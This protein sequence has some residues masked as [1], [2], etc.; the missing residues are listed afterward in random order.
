MRKGLSRSLLK[1][2]RNI[3]LKCKEFDSSSSINAIFSSCE[4]SDYLE[5]LRDA[6]SPSERID[7]VISCLLRNP[8]EDKPKFVE[9]LEILLDRYDPIDPFFDELSDCISRVQ[10]E[11]RG[12]KKID[13][14]PFIILAMTNDEAL[15]ML[16]EGASIPEELR[17]LFPSLVSELKK[18]GDEHNIDL[19]NR[20]GKSREDW[21]PYIDSD[22]SIKN[23][24]ESVCSKYNNIKCSE[25][26]KSMICP[27]F[28]SEEFF[29]DIGTRKKLLKSGGIFIIDPFSLFHHKLFRTLSL[30]GV[31][32]ENIP[33]NIAILIQS[34]V[35]SR[36]LNINGLIDNMVMSIANEAYRRYRD[37][38]DKKFEISVGD[39]PALN[40]WLF[41]VI[42]EEVE[43]INS[44]APCP[45]SVLALEK[46]L[47][48][49]GSKTSG[50]MVSF[51]GGNSD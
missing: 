40:R 6:S 4:L 19:G 38:F 42:P 1:D 10:E 7:Q 34:P 13:E 31:I 2:V 26:G 36:T 16:K 51:V 33:E 15:E 22:K 17:K 8:G 47:A 49:S 5:D 37:E 11:L 27:D 41:T 21:K 30:S 14:V 32:S 20:Y 24:I 18:H 46:N 28:Q 25:K 50:K 29:N 23:I 45:S 43:Q 35:S 48:R 9:F 3:L 44:M 39:E 12:I